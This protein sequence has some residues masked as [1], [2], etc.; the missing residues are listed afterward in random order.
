[1]LEIR[2]TLGCVTVDFNKL[3]LPSLFRALGAPQATRTLAGIARDEDLGPGG[4]PGD[5][6]SAVAISPRGRARAL[7][8]AR[9]PG[10][11]AGLMCVP[12]LAAA[13]S[14]SLRFT[15]HPAVRDGVGFRAGQT[16]GTLQGPARDVLT[17]ERTLLNL[18][19]RLSG[20][21]SLTRAY[22]RAMCSKGSVRARLF[23]TRKT[24]PG[25]R[26]LEKYAVRCGGGFCHRV[27]LFDA[28]LIKD[29]HIA[30][31]PLWDLKSWV[32]STARKAK[33]L[34]PRFFEVEVDSVDQLGEVLI[35]RVGGR[36]AA[37]IVLL[38]N[39]GPKLLCRAVDMRDALAPGVELEASGGIN[40]ETIA[41]AAAT[42]VDRI[43]VGALTHSA[44]IVDLGLDFQ[45][46]QT[47][48]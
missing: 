37:D 27:G 35:A 38:D 3:S 9:E 15:L 19:S 46:R 4:R 5:L 10:V 25:L 32:E 42:G 41:A 39:M 13:F 33:L 24:T 7:L 29:N 8:R 11:A 18:V 34:R 6:T 26:V 14:R 22:N 21:A 16:L 45:T 20:I 47:H 2:R 44:R 31:V 36:P 30:S 1:M 12:I 40:L 43:S 23:D 28:V 17:F 48:A